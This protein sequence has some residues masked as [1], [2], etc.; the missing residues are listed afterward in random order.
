M[1]KSRV[2]HW[3]NIVRNEHIAKTSANIVRNEH[4]AKA[5]TSLGQW[6][7]LVYRWKQE[8][9]WII[10]Y[11]IITTEFVSSK[12]KNATFFLIISWFL[13]VLYEFNLIWSTMKLI[14]HKEVQKNENIDWDLYM[15]KHK[16]VK[17]RKNY[18]WTKCFKFSTGRYC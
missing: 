1:W 3:P 10:N 17:S 4:I 2:V 9:L 12:T 14:T 11:V 18:S 15:I 16:R 5:L 13:C 7:I 6:C 8:L